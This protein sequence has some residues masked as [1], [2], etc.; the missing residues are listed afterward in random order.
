MCLISCGHD[1]HG[2]LEKELGKRLWIVVVDVMLGVFG[3]GNEAGR[4]GL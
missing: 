1:L 3:V 2:S 4:C